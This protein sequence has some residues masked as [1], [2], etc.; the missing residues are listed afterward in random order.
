[1]A[2]TL[3]TTAILFGIVVI[4]IFLFSRLERKGKATKIGLQN[5]LIDDI[6]FN[7][8]LELTEKENINHYFLGI[9]KLNFSLLYLNFIQQDGG[10]VLIDLWKIKSVKLNTEDTFIYK[11]VKG[12]QVMVDKRAGILKIGVE[13]LEGSQHADLVLYDYSTAVEDFVSIKN[14]AGYWCRLINK[15]IEEIKGSKSQKQEFA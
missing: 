2:S 6:I 12:K 4:F 13:F 1:M 7:K 5:D 3:F 9:D 14:R 8:K 15:A 11:Q 10:P